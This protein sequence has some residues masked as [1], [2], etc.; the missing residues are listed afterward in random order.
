MN[1]QISKAEIK[2]LIRDLTPV[3]KAVKK[4][5][6]DARESVHIYPYGIP[7]NTAALRKIPDVVATLRGML[8]GNA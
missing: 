2:A 5:P 8:D 7:V 3:A 6:N 4:I 1:K